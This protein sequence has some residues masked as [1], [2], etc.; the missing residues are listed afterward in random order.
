MKLICT[1]DTCK[2]NEHC[3]DCTYNGTLVINDDGECESYEHYKDGGE[4]QAIY[5]KACAQGKGY[6]K[7][8][9]MIGRGRR[10]EIN[11]FVVYYEAKDLTPETWCT[12]E[13][14][15]VGAAYSK[16]A[17]PELAV[18]MRMSIANLPYKNVKDLP[19]KCDDKIYS[20]IGAGV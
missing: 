10:H 8:Y 16:F 9:K 13:V 1:N 11:G 12:E 3:R 14:S 15:G 4:Y 2:Y 5:F 18:L 6:S 20:S 17:S 19:F 7:Y